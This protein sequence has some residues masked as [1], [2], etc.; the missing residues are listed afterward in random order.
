MRFRLKTLNIY[1]TTPPSKDLKI[2]KKIIP[3]NKKYY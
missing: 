1:V 2:L 3:M